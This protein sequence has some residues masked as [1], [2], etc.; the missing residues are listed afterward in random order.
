MV[1]ALRSF[2]IKGMHVGLASSIMLDFSSLSDSR[3]RL[4]ELLTRVF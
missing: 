2:W 1:M 4:G 3:V